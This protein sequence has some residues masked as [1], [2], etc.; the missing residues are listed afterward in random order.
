MPREKGVK[1][2]DTGNDELYKMPIGK[3]DLPTELIMQ[4]FWQINI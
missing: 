3:R 4:V 1:E 2:I